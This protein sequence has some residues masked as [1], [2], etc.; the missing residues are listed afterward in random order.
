[1]S[2]L[3]VP[4]DMF[5]FLFGAV[6]YRQP[7]SPLPRPKV[8][9]NPVVVRFVSFAAVFTMRAPSCCVVAS[10]VRSA[11]ARHEAVLAACSWVFAGTCNERG[12]GPPPPN[13]RP[14]RSCGVCLAATNTSGAPWPSAHSDH[15]IL[16]RSF[17][18][19]PRSHITVSYT[20]RAQ[21]QRFQQ[22]LQV[23]SWYVNVVAYDGLSGVSTSTAKYIANSRCS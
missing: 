18:A 21:L 7:H 6:Q 8:G 2:C 9:Y 5:P 16:K 10:F 15:G 13:S 14:N 20:V 1:M 19:S 12:P 4:H 11:F 3:H 22:A 23:P 17:S